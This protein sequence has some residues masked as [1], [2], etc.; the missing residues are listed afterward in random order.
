MKIGHRRRGAALS[1][2]LCLIAAASAAYGS[3]D[4]CKNYGS[5]LAYTRSSD[6][7]PVE[8]TL[9]DDRTLATLAIRI[10]KTFIA[11]AGSL[12]SG[13]QCRIWIEMFWPSLSPA[14]PTDFNERRV[15]D[16]PIGDLIGWRPLTIGVRIEPRALHS[17]FATSRYCGD[18]M[19]LK[20]LEERP[21]GLRALDEGRWPSHR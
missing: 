10:P 14:G 17:W 21:F 19:R 15:R 20:E 9:I 12:N 7:E 3:D 8:L 16:R 5:A 6:P 13:T 18:R 2:S 4:P 11:N 1:V